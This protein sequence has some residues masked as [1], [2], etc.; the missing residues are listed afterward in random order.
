MLFHIWK[1]AK[2]RKWRGGSKS[3]KL[4]NGVLQGR[5]EGTLQTHPHSQC[6][7]GSNLRKYLKELQIGASDGCPCCGADLSTGAALKDR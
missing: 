2:R 4:G 1:L 5:A 7:R 3:Y 6:H